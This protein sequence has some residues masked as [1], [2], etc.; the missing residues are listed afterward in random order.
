MEDIRELT[1]RVR[2]GLGWAAG[3]RF[4]AQAINWALTLATIRFL[5]PEEYGL[6]AM[7]MTITGFLQSFSHAGFADAIVQSR[8]ITDTEMRG[9]FGLILLVNSACL[10][11][12]CLLAYPAAF[13]YDEPRLVPLIQTSSLLFVTIALQTI[14]RATLDKRLDVKTVSRAELVSTVTGGVLV[15]TLAMLGA[16]AWSL[17]IGVLFTSFLRMVALNYAAP[18]FRL[19]R[20]TFHETSRIFSIGWLRTGE[21]LLWYLYTNADIFII[22]KML[23][24]D[25]LGIY[26]VARNLAALP[27]Q[28]LA[29]VVRPVAFP[30]FAQLQHDH[31]RALFYLRKAMRL[32]AFATFPVFFGISCVAPWITGIILGPKWEAATLPLAILALATTLRPVGLIV[33]AFLFGLGEF[34]ASFRNTVFA[35]ILFPAAFLLG[36]YWGL[37]G[38][39]VASLFAYP[40]HLASLLRRVAL[41]TKR[42]LAWLIQP[43]LSPFA[44]ALLMYVGVYTLSTMLPVGAR[45]IDSLA[46][47]VTVGGIIY[48][49]YSLVFLRDLFGE[50]WS[51]ARR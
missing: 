16:G 6:M 2:S 42:P 50:F 15:L 39:C 11:V 38:V 28:K 24:P 43:L 44:G 49:A 19:P 31:V 30:A 47:L 36:S 32:I 29:L 35:S 27:L 1:H 34:K 25:M 4:L 37:I 5:R 46:L 33:P 21:N 14:P 51:L 7:T 13:F 26:S 45:P 48:L 40:I 18:Y 20:F 8:D 3:T 9:A 41:V 22:G 23:G 10:I 12:V 17:V